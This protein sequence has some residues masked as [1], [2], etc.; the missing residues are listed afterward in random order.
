MSTPKELINEVVNLTRDLDQ[1]WPQLIDRISNLRGEND[2]SVDLTATPTGAS[3]SIS[4]IYSKITVISK[5][6]LSIDSG[7]DNELLP[8]IFVE[9][10]L[11]ELK[12]IYTSIEDSQSLLS[13]IEENGG[14]GEFNPNEFLIV[15]KKGGF[16]YNINDDLIS[17]V[18]KSIE[19]IILNS[20]PWI[21]IWGKGDE[22]ELQNITSSLRTLMEQAYAERKA[23]SEACQQTKKYM[24]Q[25]E[26]FAE[27]SNKTLAE[28]NQTKTQSH[29]HLQEI[30]SIKSDVSKNKT[31]IEQR[32]TEIRTITEK[33]NQLRETVDNY[34]ATFQSFQEHLD[35]LTGAHDKGIAEQAVLLSS[36]KEIEK[37]IENINLRAEQM[38]SGATVAGLASEFGDAR[39]ALSTELTWAGRAFYLAILL[40]A[41]SV[42]PMGLLFFPRFDPILASTINE[43]GQ[44]QFDFAAQA[45]V[46][47]L[48]IVPFAWLAK[49]T[50]ARHGRLF[51]LREHYSYK[52]TLAA[53]VDGFKHQA[54][55]LE[56]EIA[57]VVFEA[58]SFNPADRMD[59][60]VT[61]EKVPHPILDWLVSRLSEER[62]RG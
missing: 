8:N 59:T 45:I 61:K 19:S 37:N 7:R 21:L 62:K 35:Q 17:P 14:I 26:G 3:S 27:N 38:L 13:S 4:D 60:G 18:H 44:P 2:V 16:E 41:F 25:A 47:L 51:R 39:N 32:L 31:E 33:S 9:N 28:I 46:R 56:Q 23:A 12:N 11:N 10:L 6:I 53:S 22:P 29:E 15:S 49:F 57:A 20:Y 30:A 5:V 52:H 1:I 24:Q 42:I 55:D 40:L 48:I 34:Q 50:A 58:L 43:L 36:L 54:P